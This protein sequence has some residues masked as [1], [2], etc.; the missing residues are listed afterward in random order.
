MQL[1]YWEQ[2]TYFENVD[3]AIVGSGIVGL[4][5]ALALKTQHP[6]LKIL[7]LERGLLPTGASTKN[8]GFACF[9]SVTEL[10]DDLNTSTENE[11]FA[12]VERRYR[13]LE[14]LRSNLS[15]QV[16]DYQN[17]G[18]Y[19]LIDDAQNLD[20]LDR[21]NYLLKPITGL[22]HTYIN[23]TEKIKSFQFQNINHL[24]LN[25]AEGQ[26]DTGKMMAAL[27]AKV[28]S[29]GVTI[30]NQTEITSFHQET[31]YT[32]LQTNHNLEIKARKLLICTNGFAQQLLPDLEVEPARAQVLITKPIE[33]LPFQ[34]TFHCEKGYYY[35]R[36]I[37]SR[38][39]FGGGR[40]LD[41]KTEKTTEFNLTDKIQSHLDHLLK[42]VILP[43]TPFEVDYRWSGI[44][45]VGPKKSPIVKS[46]S[47]N[48]FCAV[49]LGGMGVAIGS[50]VGEEAAEMV[51][52]SL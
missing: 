28:C 30:L 14:K 48:I 49:R 43:E 27:T 20:H 42:T 18:G 16:I 17:L 24:I 7:V 1:S 46:I 45:G 33:N 11:V 39:L 9:G 29:L 26:I 25:Q 35:F 44:M 2:K 41:F 21:F 6:S 31:S 32:T 22:D 12:L 23:A 34:G 38:I 37:E 50:L 19:E 47:E 5:A 15:D 3:V 36:N 40:N 51:A 13:G 4:N 8:A 10:L 52:R